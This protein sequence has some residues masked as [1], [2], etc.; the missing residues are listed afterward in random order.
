MNAPLYLDANA[1]TPADPAVVAAML[2][3]FTEDYGNPAA[4][5]HAYGWAADEAVGRAREQTG[6]LLGLPPE[7]IVFTSGA[8]EAL[9]MAL[10]GLAGGRPG[11]HIVTTA[12]EHAAVLET[13]RALEREGAAVTYVPPEPD[14]AVRAEAVAEALRPETVLVAVMW[15]NNETG[16]L[17]PVAEIA[18]VA[19]RRRV[20]F[21]VDAAQAAGKVPVDAALADLLV[22]AAHKF[23]GP[24]GV[25]A[26]AFGRPL[27]L[28]PL[29]DGGG[30]EG[31]LRG[32]TLNVP[33]IV[34]MGAAAERAAAALAAGE[35]ARQAAARDRLE[36]ALCACRPAAR[37]N[38]AAAPRLPQTLSITF[39]GVPAA[40]LMAAAR[41]LAFSAGSACSSG[42]GRPS[43][44]LRAM[45]LSDADA[46]ATIRL[47]FGRFTPE[48][49]LAEA[50]RRLCRALDDLAA[51]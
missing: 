47:S 50:A 42:A 43:H 46:L 49:A 19:R 5:A 34:G 28:R 25:G 32:G 3:Y 20:R 39:P 48:D 15:A 21:L 7:R 40:A 14:G 16:V 8:T 33:G 35:P 6:A 10:K 1:T 29:L 11:A 41:T 51:V 30:Q 9:N 24:K 26:L 45:G 38:G 2:P 27:R 44:V 18:E 23:H 36:A 22:C 31:G 17:Q 37:V 4:R 13:C 12:I